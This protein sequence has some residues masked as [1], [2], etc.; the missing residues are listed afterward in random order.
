MKGSHASK[1]KGIR[2]KYIILKTD[3]IP[4]KTVQGKYRPTNY[5]YAF[6]KLSW[7]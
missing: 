6:Q 2:Q 3:M 1:N 7:H 5:E 4:N